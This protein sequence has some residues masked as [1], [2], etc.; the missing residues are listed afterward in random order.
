LKIMSRQSSWAAALS[1]AVLLPA[2]ATEAQ[3]PPP[4]PPTP[5]APAPSNH[6]SYLT[7]HGD[8]F[9]AFGGVDAGLGGGMEFGSFQNR[10]IAAGT[11]LSFDREGPGTRLPAA[12]YFGGGFSFHIP[13]GEHVLVIPAFSL[14][15]RL[16]DSAAG[17][18]G[19]LAAFAQLGAAYRFSQFYVGLEAERP[20]YLELPTQKS[21]FFPNLTSGGA[22]VGLYF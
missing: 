12:L 5:A 15:Y 7:L 8:L 2:F 21:A 20:V 17:I 9:R 3:T 13:I 16:V 22:F 18:G 11:V 1:L 4:P 6:S 19:G 10:F 14:G